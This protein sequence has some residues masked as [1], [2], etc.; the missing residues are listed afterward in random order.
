MSQK[1]KNHRET[2]A[3]LQSPDSVIESRPAEKP[4]QEYPNTLPRQSTG[5]AAGLTW[6]PL[7]VLVVIGLSV[8]V[9]LAKI[10]KVF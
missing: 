7:F 9:V 6:Q 4:P 2:I 8:L 10:L 1:H 5:E 3:D